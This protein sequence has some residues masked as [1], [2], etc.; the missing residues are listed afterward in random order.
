M[1]CKHCFQPIEKNTIRS[2]PEPNPH[3][4][5]KHVFGHLWHCFDDQNNQLET[6]AE[7]LEEV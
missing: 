7:P 6:V 2:S 3:I 4:K 1:T 5:Y